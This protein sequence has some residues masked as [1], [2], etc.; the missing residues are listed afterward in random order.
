MSGWLIVIIVIIGERR[1]D[2]VSVAG[3]ERFLGDLYP[4]HGALPVAF[5]V[6]PAWTGDACALIVQRGGASTASRNSVAAARRVFGSAHIRDLNMP[7]RRGG[8]ER[9]YDGI[10]LKACTVLDIE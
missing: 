5:I 10:N 4:M 3:A 6:P 9:R 8:C 2:N 1:W 7:T